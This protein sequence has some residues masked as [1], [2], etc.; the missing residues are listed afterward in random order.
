[1]SKSYGFNQSI[2]KGGLTKDPELKYT[3]DGLAYL[4]FS[5]ACSTRVRKNGQLED[6]VDYVPCK[7]W[8]SYAEVIGKYC[9]KG[10]QLLVIG[11]IRTDKYEGK[12]GKTVWSTYTLVNNVMFAGGKRRDETQ[13]AEAANV[14]PDM[15]TDFSDCAEDIPF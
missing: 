1:M 6:V 8:G 9:V 5:L 12:D 11:R 7:A 14:N 4:T 13:P 2:L 10:T 15:G 3:K